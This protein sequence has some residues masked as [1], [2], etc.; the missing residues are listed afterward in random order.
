MRCDVMCYIERKPRVR[1]VKVPVGRC[2]SFFSSEKYIAYLH[3]NGFI[4]TVL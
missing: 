4:F 3:P 2:V 1:E